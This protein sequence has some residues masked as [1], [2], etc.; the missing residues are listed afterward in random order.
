MRVR[1]G[2]FPEGLRAEGRRD[3]VTDIAEQRALHVC[4]LCALKSAHPAGQK[5][6]VNLL[7]AGV[8]K[9]EQLGGNEF[10]EGRCSEGLVACLLFPHMVGC[11]GA[12]GIHFQI[13][14]SGA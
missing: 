7:C 10:T 4:L 12:A 14:V 11:G 5:C 3:Q 8:F 13:L 9:S 1:S 6:V 2:C